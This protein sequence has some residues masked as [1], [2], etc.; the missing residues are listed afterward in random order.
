MK[1][2][3]A[4]GVSIAVL[5]G[6]SL[7]AFAADLPQPAQPVIYDNQVSSARFDWSG[8]YFG[9]NLGWGWGQFT[10]NSAL[11]GRF[12]SDASGV[13]GGVHAGYNHAITPNIIAGLEADFQLSDLEKRRSVAGVGVKTSSDWNS[14]IRGRLGYAFDRFMIYGTGGLSI[15]DLEVAAAGSKGNETAIGWTLGAGIEGAVTD[16]VTA[17]LE[18]LY[19]DF[20]R[21]SFTLGGTRYRTDLDASIARFGV[22]YKF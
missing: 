21:E 6:A 13:N 17:R 11:T 10:T 19:Q 9:G 4:A 5:A 20:G 16:N 7:P 14:T 12:N 3:A 8:F 18:Y 2:L 1:S 15:A 22:S